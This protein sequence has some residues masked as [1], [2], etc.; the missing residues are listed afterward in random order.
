S[1]FMA[2]TP[3]LSNSPLRA[4]SRIFSRRLTMASRPSMLTTFGLAATMHP[5]LVP[6][7]PDD[8]RRIKGERTFMAL[9]INSALN[10]MA[11]TMLHY[12]FDL[13]HRVRGPSAAFNSAEANSSSQQQ[14]KVL[15]HPLAMPL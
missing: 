2:A 7:M 11:I 12:P 10:L 14:R 13:T 4:S 5:S 9:A 6:S 1:L 8:A 3:T 15:S